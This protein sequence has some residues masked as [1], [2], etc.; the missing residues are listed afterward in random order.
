MDNCT[1]KRLGLTDEILIFEE[2]WL[3]SIQEGGITTNIIRAK[4]TYTPTYCRKCG[5]KNEGQIIKYG[6]H[7]TTVQL[8]PFRSAKTVLSLDRS[9]FLC[10]ECHSTFNAQTN[11]VEERCAISKELK[12]QVALDLAK[13]TCIKDIAERY[14]VS[15]VTVT[16]VMRKCQETYK[17]NFNYLPSVL[18]FDEFKSM[19]S[20]S[21]KMSFVFMDG[22]TNKLIG[23]LENR[24]LA[25]LKAYFLKFSR[26]TRAKV[27]Y[28]V[29]DMN[30]PYFELAK[31][32]FPN[33][34]I[35]TDRFH[36]IQQITRALNQ[37]RI[38][39]MNK[40]H[41]TD[42]IKYKRLKRF[43]KLFLKNAY[44]LDSSNDKYNRSFRRPMTEKSIIDDLLS[45]DDQLSE[46]YE[47]CQLLLYH[48]KQKDTVSFF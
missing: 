17:P 26:K 34:Q 45:Y 13:V 19:K 38:Q 21:G 25:F 22:H 16:R 39:T 30:A 1:K 4:L 18:C 37:L 46:A 43:W 47:I 36:I 33:A 40:Y 44:H 15:D 11:L 41:K 12:Q 2:D 31:T 8:L 14:F 24:R 9:R 42:S 20:C 23:V 6:K 28:I 32:V 7:N 48:F 10:K 35:V 3:D 29:M 5:I 27:K